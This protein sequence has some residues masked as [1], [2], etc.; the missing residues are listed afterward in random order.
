MSTPSNFSAAAVVTGRR[1]AASACRESW[2]LPLAGRYNTQPRASRSVSSHR[3]GAA[4]PLIFGH[5]AVVVLVELLEHCTP[6]RRAA[7]SEQAQSAKLC[8]AE[9]R[10]RLALRAAVGQRSRL[11]PRARAR[12][13]STRAT[14][15]LTAPLLTAAATRI[16][17]RICLSVIKF[18][19]RMASGGSHQPRSCPSACTPSAAPLRLRMAPEASARAR[20][21]GEGGGRRARVPTRRA[22]K[23]RPAR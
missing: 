14:S 11:R 6:R 18:G 23:A 8:M 10:T 20:V 4:H 9:S 16:T 21:A 12:H 3:A 17:R 19:G 15:V 13:T 7:V 1:S 2:L 5:C 22:S